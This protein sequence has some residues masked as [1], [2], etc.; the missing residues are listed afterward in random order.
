MDKGSG[1]VTTFPFSCEPG[2]NVVKF[3]VIYHP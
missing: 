2:Q 3:W 1:W